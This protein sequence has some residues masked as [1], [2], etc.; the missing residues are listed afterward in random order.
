[1]IDR[2]QAVKHRYDE[3]G[4]LMS[5]PDVVSNLPLLQQYAREHAQLAPVVTL[6]GELETVQSGIDDARAILNDGADDELRELAREM[7]VEYEPRRDEIEGELRR[8]L[9]PR[10]P[11]DA[12]NAI[13]E[14][15]ASA[16]GEEAALFAR[17]L[18]RM[19]ALYAEQQGWKI[20]VMNEAE[21]DLGGYKEIIFEVSGDGGYGKLKYESGVHRVQRIP[22]TESGG[23][24]HT[25][26][27]SVNVLPEAEEFDID[28]RPEDLR[29]DVYRSSGHGGQ[30]VN[31]TDS[32]VRITHLPT[33]MVV[34]CQN[35][36]SQLQN[37]ASAMAV[38]RS[39]LYE[40]EQERR[41]K[42]LGE[43]RRSQVQSG[44]RAEKIRTYNFP[45]DRVTDHR[46]GLTMH[47]LPSVLEGRIG[48]F[49][50][51]LMVRDEA[52]RLDDDG[53]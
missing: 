21:S 46:I 45:Q 8:L 25:S 23:R 49:I 11:N 28:I 4:R 30:G 50:E 15:R 18:F 44:D 10:D 22:V 13:M 7:L 39:R 27:V 42:E 53:P 6:I 5:D 37:R 41:A 33:G 47:N 29:I 19:Y 12:K 32:A 38:L 20:E 40:R 2:L 51:E 3:L 31:T 36:R 14:I 9:V 35:E 34:T 1:M 16:G 24:I 26:T 17:E 48:P 43:T 52:E